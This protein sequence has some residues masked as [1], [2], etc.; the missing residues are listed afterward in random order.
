M[1]VKV[2]VDS[3]IIIDFFL[4]RENY[5]SAAA[6]FEFASLGNYQLL[7]SSL[8]MSNVF[9]ICCRYSTKSNVLKQIKEFRKIISIVCVD[10]KAFDKALDSGFSDFEDAMQNFAAVQNKVKY[11][12]TR[13]KSD[14]KKSKLQVLNP[15]EFLKKNS[16]NCST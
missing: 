8:V 10:E 9:Y 4:S 15:T 5:D 6:L 14:F 1:T 11:I 12:L 13:N 16:Y 7:T 3:D 2:F